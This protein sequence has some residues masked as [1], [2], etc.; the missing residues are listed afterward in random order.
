MSSCA[1]AIGSYPPVAAFTANVTSGTVPLTVSFTDQSTY[2][3][4]H[5]AW[6]FGDGGTSNEQHPT[7][8]YISAGTYNVTLYATNFEGTDIQTKNGY[9]TAIYA[10]VANF[11]ASAT[12]GTAPFAVTFTDLSTNSPT[13]WAWDFG[14]GATSSAQNPTHTYTSAGN[15]AVSLNVSNVGGYNLST[16]TGYITVALSSSGSSGS[17]TR[18][19]VSPGQPPEIVKSTHTSV[20]HIIGGTSV[21][22]DLSGTGSPVFAVSFDAKDNEGLVVMKVQVLS[23]TP[24]GI[25]T[26]SGNFDQLMSIDVGS[27]GTISSHNADNILIRF[28]VSREWIRENNIDVSTIRMT[29]YHDGQWNDLPTQNENEDDEFLYFVAETPG[30]SIFSVAGDE[31]KA[32]Q[33][34]SYDLADETPEE[35][36]TEEGKSTPGFTGLMGLVFVSLAFIVSRR[37]RL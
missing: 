21:E 7:H 34:V 15:Y 13:A 28:K 30:F 19:S 5:W 32:V 25:S 24:E 36:V 9:I 2:S 12:S 37:S 27:Q 22:Y 10:P 11:T 18:A 1:S 33:P 26:P 4:T 3:P 17:G 20:K 29:R 35:P 6:N 8:T 31:V 14:D 16:Q 23:S